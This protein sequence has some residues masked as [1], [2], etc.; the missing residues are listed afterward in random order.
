MKTGNCL[1]SI[2][3]LFKTWRGYVCVNSQAMQ[4]CLPCK[5]NC[6]SYSRQTQDPSHDIPQTCPSL[7]PEHTSGFWVFNTGMSVLGHF[8]VTSG[9]LVTC[10]IQD[11][12]PTTH[13]TG[14]VVLWRRAHVPCSC[15]SC[16]TSCSKEAVA[17]KRKKT[18]GGV[19]KALAS[20][21]TDFWSIWCPT[22]RVKSRGSWGI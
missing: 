7:D 17:K 10:Q 3:R 19:V 14:F 2:L 12:W 21:K 1:T 11:G 5:A 13:A 22:S 6:L 15:C 4:K 9:S 16:R 8:G 18:K 20:A